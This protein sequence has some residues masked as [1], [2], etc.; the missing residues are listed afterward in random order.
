MTE[1]GYVGHLKC[2]FADSGR[3]EIDHI[4]AG[5]GVLIHSPKEKTA[6]G[7]HVMDTYSPMPKPQNPVRYADT[8]IP[9]AL[10]LLCDKGAGSDLQVAI[11]GGAGLAEMPEKANIG[12]RIVSAVKDAIL[13][14]DLSIGFEQTGGAKIR[15]MT[16]DLESERTEITPRK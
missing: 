13:K 7:L 11:A 2:L 8:A 10:A 5:V 1:V 6:V 15:Q 9:Y 12:P 14:A 4:G 16:L 3:L